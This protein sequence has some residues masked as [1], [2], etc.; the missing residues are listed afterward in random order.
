MA[1]AAASG[2]SATAVVLVS[3]TEVRYRDWDVVV[4]EDGEEEEDGD[5]EKGSYNADTSK[6]NIIIVVIRAPNCGT[7]N[8]YLIR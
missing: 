6:D 2:L 5:R 3:L 4:D 7:V 8:L 1:S